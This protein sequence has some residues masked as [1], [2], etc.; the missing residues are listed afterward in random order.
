MLK[1]FLTSCRQQLCTLLVSSGASD[2]LTHRT[3]MRKILIDD[4]AQRSATDSSI[5]SLLQAIDS[6]SSTF[7]QEPTVRRA[8]RRR[9]SIDLPSSR[10]AISIKGRWR[11]GLAPYLGSAI[12]ELPPGAQSFLAARLGLEVPED[13]WRNAVDDDWALHAIRRSNEFLRLDKPKQAL[14][15]LRQRKQLWSD[16]GLLDEAYKAVDALLI[17]AARTYERTRLEQESG[18]KRTRDMESIMVDVRSLSNEVS[19]AP[20]YIEAKFARG[21]AGDRVVALALAQAHPYPASFDLVIAAIGSA[22][23]PFEQ[24]HGLML[25]TSLKPIPIEKQ[26]ALREALLNPKGIPFHSS[27][28]SRLKLRDRLLAQLPDSPLRQVADL[29]TSKSSAMKHK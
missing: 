16:A 2:K 27:D 10:A 4:L 21:Q 12:Q 1:R 18:N 20:D 24:Y 28:S 29:R 15:L 23:S 7:T 22:L 11:D 14:D 9:F 13:V 19:I 25:A 6:R 17:A 8:G 26:A 5:K 3:D